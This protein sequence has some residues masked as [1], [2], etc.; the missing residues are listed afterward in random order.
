MRRDR[1]VNSVE[2]CGWFSGLT[3]RCSGILFW[4]LAITTPP[5]PGF[6]EARTEFICTHPSSPASVTKTPAGVSL[7]KYSTFPPTSAHS[8]SPGVLACWLLRLILHKPVTPI[9]Q[10]HN[11]VCLPF[12][13]LAFANLKLQTSSQPRCLT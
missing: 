11:F 9:L 8:S 13:T 6:H 7:H 3:N 2:H 1:P 4:S 10:P 5:P 12:V